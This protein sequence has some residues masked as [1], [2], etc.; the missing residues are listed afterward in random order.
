MTRIRCTIAIIFFQAFFI[1]SQVLSLHTYTIRDGLPSNTIT[2]ITQDSRGFLWIGTYDGISMYDGSEFNNIRKQDGLG[3]FVVISEAEKRNGSGNILVGTIKGG[4]SLVNNTKI[5]HSISLAKA[6]ETS[7]S[8][9]VEDANGLFWCAIDEAVVTIKNGKV[10]DTVFVFPDNIDAQLALYGNY[11]AVGIA[12]KIHFFSITGKEIKTIS[13]NTNVTILKLFVDQNRNLWVT[14]S[15]NILREFKDFN[16]SGKCILP[17]S[18]HDIALDPDGYIWLATRKGLIKLP[19]N[20]WKNGKAAVYGLKNGLPDENISCL[21]IDAEKNLWIGTWN[22]GLVKL[23][24]KNTVKFY[25]PGKV[26]NQFL[27]IDNNENVWQINV[28]NKIIE[29]YRESDESW[30]YKIHV[31]NLNGKKLNG[32]IINHGKDSL[33]VMLSNGEIV[34]YKIQHFHFRASKLEQKNIFRILSADHRSFYIHIDKMHR[35]WCSVL[36]SDTVMVYQLGKKLKLLRTLRYPKDLSV[37]SVRVIESDNYGNTWLGGFDDGLVMISPD[38][39]RKYFSVK[40]GLTDNSI[41]SIAT[42]E[43]GRV[44]IG[45]RYGGISVFNGSHFTNITTAGGLL[46]NT[47]WSLSYSGRHKMWIGSPMGSM[48]VSTNNLN[49]IGWYNSITGNEIFLCVTDTEQHVWARSADEITFSDFGKKKRNMIPPPVYISGIKI[50]GNTI[51]SN[52]NFIEVPYYKN[53]WAIGYVGLTYRDENAVRF[54]Y[55]LLG[56]NAEWSMPIKVRSITF[57]AL[58][59]GKYKFE[60]KAINSDGV[61]SIKPASL[62]FTILQPFWLR[63]WFLLI[64]GTLLLSIMVFMVYLRINRLKEEQ[65]RQTKFSQLMIELQEKERK[66][67]ASEL[68]DGLGQNLLIIKNLAEMGNAGL[69]VNTKQNLNDISKIAGRSVA[70][71]REIAYNLRPHLLDKLGLTKSLKSMVRQFGESSNISI[72]E[73]ICRLENI[74]TPDEEMNI[75]RIVQEGINNIIKHSDATEASINVTQKNNLIS[76]IIIDNGRGFSISKNKKMPP[77][78]TGEFGLITMS[79]RVKLL[80]GFLNV[81]SEPGKGTKIKIKIPINKTS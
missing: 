63:W 9:I 17:I 4:I 18:A 8:S 2:C 64:F 45:T 55:K 6:A 65:T 68:H 5:A 34:L 77:S 78:K 25:V 20:N 60:V 35:L 76:I 19:Y 40:N 33:W 38:W 12:N 47:I 28:P 16:L 7:P 81:S 21:F 61:E 1:Y 13:F 22:K 24:D 70:E 58:K 75:Y 74:F 46:S 29:F 14:T 15:D 10:N 44:W 30:Q 66:R 54:Q 72:S 73:K 79:E 23:T 80:R 37:N 52:K 48:W 26:F 27:T 50:N 41:R 36:A 3:G 59:P 39:R 57:A 56:S 62:R 69:Q 11:I 51:N 53:T 67:I 43:Y 42:D 49:R 32:Q 71:V 31:L